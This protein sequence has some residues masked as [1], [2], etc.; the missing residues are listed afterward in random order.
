MQ[1]IIEHFHEKLQHDL[2]FTCCSCERLLV[3]K[4]VTHFHI[5]ADKFSSSTWVQLKN[6]FEKDPDVGKKTLYVCIHCQLILNE[7]CL[8]TVFKM[9]CTLNQCQKNCLV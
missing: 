3:E 6:L 1:K 7:E 2:D 9:V 4:D 8:D 5:S